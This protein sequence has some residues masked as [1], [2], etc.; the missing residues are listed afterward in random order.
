[1]RTTQPHQYLMLT[2]KG[3]H[4]Q[5]AQSFKYLGIDMPATSSK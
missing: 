1:M 3:E 2:F 4:A 5:F